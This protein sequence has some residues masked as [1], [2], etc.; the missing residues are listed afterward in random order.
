M[1]LR[2]REWPL[3]IN[4]ILYIACLWPFLLTRTGRYADALVVCR[5]SEFAQLA[6]AVDFL[7]FLDAN[8]EPSRTPFNIL[9]E[10]NPLELDTIGGSRHLWAE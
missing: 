7:A 3:D 1:S 6:G 8:K 4:S 10:V 2:I 9:Y 5:I